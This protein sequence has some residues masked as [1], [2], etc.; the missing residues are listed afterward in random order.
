MRL[1]VCCVFA[2]LMTDCLSQPVLTQTKSNPGVGEALGAVLAT[3]IVFGLPFYLRAVQ[4]LFSIQLKSV[5]VA[6]ERRAE[7]TNTFSMYSLVFGFVFLVSMAML[8]VSFAH[9]FSLSRISHRARKGKSLV[10][11]RGL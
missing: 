11:V 1:V 8:E 7:V 5:P 10:H 4:N 6:E 3:S 9:P 2:L